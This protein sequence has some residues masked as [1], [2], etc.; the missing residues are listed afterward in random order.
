MTGGVAWLARLRRWRRWILALGTLVAVRAALPPILR[1]V[2]ASQASKALNAQVEIGD[3]DL[4]LFRGAIALLDVAIRPTGGASP[5]EGTGL[6]DSEPEPLIVWKRLA[7]EIRWLPLLRKTVQ[8]REVALEAP[9]VTLDRLESGELNLLALVPAASEETASEPHSDMAPAQPGWSF[10]IDH[11]ALGSGSLRFRDLMLRDA[12]PMEV[13]VDS[14]DVTEMAVRPG[15]YVEPARIRIEL[16][17][18]EGTVRVDASLTFREKG[19]A[20]EANVAADGLSLRRGR[21]YIPNVGWSDLGGR[22]GAALIYRFETDATNQVSGSVTMRDVNVRVRELDVPALTWKTLEVHVDPVD[23]AARRVVVDRVGLSGAAV[24]V[25]LQGGVL[26]PLLAQRAMD[27]PSEPV[28]SEKEE[29]PPK[30]RP[31]DAARSEERELLPA[32]RPWQWSVGSLEI[33]DTV[34][35]LL[36]VAQSL[37]VGAQLGARDLRGEGEQPV[38]LQLALTINDGSVS[39][40]GNLRLTPPGFDG[41]VRIERLP[42]LEPVAATAA[43]PTNLLQSGELSADLTLAAGSLAPRPGDVEVGGKLSLTEPAIAAANPNE[44]AVTARS[45]DMSI[46]QVRVPRVLAAERVSAA[47]E[48]ITVDVAEL[49]VAALR[50]QLT[51]TP[52]GLVVP[53]LGSRL[54]GS[55]TAALPPS[56]PAPAAAPIVQVSV[57]SLRITDGQV[58]VTDRSVTPFYVGELSPLQVD[59]RSLRWPELAI[60]RILVDATTAEK[61]TIKVTGSLRPSGSELQVSGR[62]VALPQ[63]NPYATKF[64][65]FSVSRGSASVS[66]K[67]SFDKGRYQAYSS[68]TLHDLGLGGQS[69]ESLFQ[70]QFGIPLPLALALLR[71]IHGNIVLDLPIEVDEQGARA[72][73]STTIGGALRRAIVNALASPLKLFGAVVE[74]GKVQAVAPPAIAFR[75]GRDQLAPGS[76]KEIQRLGTFVSSRPGISLTLAT[77]PSTSDAR[78]IREQALREEMEGSKGFLSGLRHLGER[79]TR[80]RIRAALEARGGGEAGELESEA[81]P[82]PACRSRW[83]RRTREMNPS[84]SCFSFLPVRFRLCRVRIGSTAATGATTPEWSDANAYQSD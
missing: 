26:L 3:V 47:P 5:A 52:E 34:V 81:R 62:E 63:F 55:E 41:R 45:I 70:Q 48:P 74:G 39:A 61:G 27:S 46:K 60:D 16:K 72:G 67:A 12:E 18:D 35:R 58:G 50:A 40:D 20:L 33:K 59:F 73:L 32:D 80:D 14:I 36:G 43:L 10:G 54:Q 51:N 69:G 7:V 13:S 23:L 6:A 30:D 65:P 24:P 56:A 11:L 64:S 22:L 4:W 38:P 9:A 68:V 31:S 21:L 19:V 75:V 57:G 84:V 79:G 44:F 25:R 2:L 42:L 78:W 15:M 83:A 8:L 71:D 29:P 17:V 82:P 77:A 1:S 66:T 76:D 53:E 28:H 37:D 49:H